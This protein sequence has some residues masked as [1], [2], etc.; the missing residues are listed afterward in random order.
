MKQQPDNST[1]RL[2]KRPHRHLCPGTQAPTTTTFPTIGDPTPDTLPLSIIVIAIIPATIPT[3]GTTTSLTP[4][5]G[6]CTPEAPS[7]KIPPSPFPPP[8]IW[9][10]SQ[11]VL[12]DIGHSPH[13]STYSVTRKSIALRR[14]HQGQGSRLASVATASTVR[15]VHAH[16]DISLVYSATC[17]GR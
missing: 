6:E 17:A 2:H 5:T 15:T 12:I 7:T 8:S 10:S 16:S 3:A 14:A 11:P 1:C 4:A 9:T 13:V